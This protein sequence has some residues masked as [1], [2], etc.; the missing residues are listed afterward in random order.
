MTKS[1]IT[2]CKYREVKCSFYK[3]KR[4]QDIFKYRSLYRQTSASVNDT[5][6]LYAWPAEL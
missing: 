5:L 3:S 6:F 2:T 1:D 4:Q